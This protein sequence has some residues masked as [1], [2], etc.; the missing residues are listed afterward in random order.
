MGESCDLGSSSRESLRRPRMA[1][2]WGRVRSN[3]GDPPNRVVLG[4]ILTLFSQATASSNRQ[5]VCRGTGDDAARPR[6]ALSAS[7]CIAKPDDWEQSSSCSLNVRKPVVFSS[8]QAHL[9]WGRATFG[10]H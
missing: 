5:S 10:T 6:L 8:K 7:N 9:K 2:A 3:H 1:G 4:P